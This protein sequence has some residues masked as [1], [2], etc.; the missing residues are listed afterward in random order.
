M[1]EEQ[2]S[3]GSPLNNPFVGPRTFTRAERH[4]YFGRDREA[5]DLLSLVIAERQV[6][7]YAMSGAGKSSLI[8]TRLLPQLTEEEG[9][10]TFPVG[11]VSGELPEGV[12]NVDNI[13]TFNLILSLECSQ[14]N[15]QRYTRM[16]LPDYLRN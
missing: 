14:A 13:F 6:L 12:E 8:N 16:T 3:Q 10:A 15:P 2:E 11:R 5:R 9:F 4:Q 1:S 7:F